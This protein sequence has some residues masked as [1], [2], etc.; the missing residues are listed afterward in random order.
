MPIVTLN[1]AL[2]AIRGR[3]GDVVFK[4]YRDKIVM[5]RVPR[6]VPGAA[7]PAQ[8]A[9]RD[10]LKAATAF[11]RRVYANTRAK[12]C[13]ADAARR[14]GRQ[15][16][17]LAISDHLRCVDSPV[18][19]RTSAECRRFAAAVRLLGSPVLSSQMPAPASTAVPRSPGTIRGEARRSP[20]T[21]GRVRRGGNREFSDR[22]VHARARVPLSPTPFRVRR[23]GRFPVLG[24]AS[25]EA[26]EWKPSA[27]G[28][29]PDLEL[30]SDGPLKGPLD[31]ANCALTRRS[32]LRNNRYPSEGGGPENNFLSLTPSAVPI[33]PAWRL[34]RAKAVASG[35]PG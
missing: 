14:L 30:G 28:P 25:G 23:V 19:D 4:T 22:G 12:A 13:Y 21:R 18:A 8:R 27:T 7:T 33:C 32:W 10:R 15:P 20:S 9:R 24:I 34:A 31:S 3:V 11:A 16:F 17:R 5:T 35:C 2:V 26:L 1:S 29:P 6:F